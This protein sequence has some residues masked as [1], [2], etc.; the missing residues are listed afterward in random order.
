MEGTKNNNAGQIKRQ[1]KKKSPVS[2]GQE[3][4]K[5]HCR[6]TRLALD[7]SPVKL[8]NNETN[9]RK[10]KEKISTNHQTEIKIIF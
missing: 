5:T 10:K 2:L 6:S 3:M 7:V 4:S 1:Q 8:T 9:K